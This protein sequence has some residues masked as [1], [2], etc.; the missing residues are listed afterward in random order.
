MRSKRTVKIK[1]GL[2]KTKKN[3]LNRSRNKYGGGS[4]HVLT[5]P[6]F[7]EQKTLIH[8][9]YKKEMK[10]QPKKTRLDISIKKVFDE[11]KKE[12]KETGKDP[13]GDAVSKKKFGWYERRMQPLGMSQILEKFNEIN[14]PQKKARETLYDFN[15]E[16]LQYI[17]SKV[18]KKERTTDK[19]EGGLINLKK[20]ERKSFKGI[21]S[22]AQR[23]YEDAKKE[24][25]EII[26][27]REIKNDLNSIIEAIDYKLTPDGIIE[28]NDYM[29]HRTSSGEDYAHNS[30]NNDV[31]E[32]YRKK[33]GKWN[34]PSYR[35]ETKDNMFSPPKLPNK[36]RRAFRK[37]KKEKKTKWPQSDTKIEGS[38]EDY[39]YW[40]PNCEKEENDWNMFKNKQFK[41]NNWYH[42]VRCETLKKKR[43]IEI[44]RK[45][46]E[47][48]NKTWTGWATGKA[49]RA[50]G[51]N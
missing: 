16:E 15:L 44:K 8:V 36:S 31:R 37:A 32:K 19:I 12:K 7:I 40:P 33:S 35:I 38:E 5:I 45:K 21:H 13:L 27:L 14:G 23:K 39:W 25:A 20:P 29:Y 41:C 28:Y 46:R 22:N 10:K 43:D 4:K 49:K 11:L 47:E 2:T 51:Y 48:E 9:D 30:R 50:M 24:Y 6:K 34:C 17:W 3:R 18:F 26:K 42:D 1:Y